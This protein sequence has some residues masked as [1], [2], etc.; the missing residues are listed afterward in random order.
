MMLQ[1]KVLSWV[2]PFIILPI[3]ALGITT[4]YQL[5][6]DIDERIANQTQHQ[7]EAA[8]QETLQYIKN[9]ESNLNWI[10]SDD[11]LRQ[12]LLISDKTLRY[13]VYQ[14]RLLD[15]FSRYRDN[16]PYI[17]EI[18]ISLPDGSEDTRL[19]MDTLKKPLNKVL[20]FP[21]LMTQPGSA[22]YSTIMEYPDKKTFSFLLTKKMIFKN[23]AEEGA[24]S[25]PR[26]RGYLTLSGDTGWL[27]NLLSNKP[28]GK[29]GHIIATNQQGEIIFDP[30]HPTGDDPPSQTSFQ[31]YFTTIN[32]ATETHQNQ[33]TN[34]TGITYQVTGRKLS[35][36]LWLFALTDKNERTNPSNNLLPLVT[37][38]LLFTLLLFVILTLVILRKILIQPIQKL[39]E[40]TQYI[41]SGK[42]DF[43]IKIHSSD[44]L[45]IL[46]II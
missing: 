33:W 8:A 15:Y 40:A 22:I 7:L 38:I 11:F 20:H 35:P 23:E 43:D 13:S 6:K 36:F 34:P 37:I 27:K 4:Y 16:F 25:I 42:L 17:R 2:M 45:G 32:G 31:Q 1:A 28:I 10:A 5:A 46:D 44:E 21:D 14:K 3:L 19:G 12:Y 41:G 26:L 9:A 24:N 29:H 18:S 39:K 30:A